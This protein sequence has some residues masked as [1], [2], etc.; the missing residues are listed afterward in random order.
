[1]PI[2]AEATRT[3]GAYLQ[4]V[5][6]IVDT[7]LDRL[8]GWRGASAH[9]SG[10]A[11]QGNGLSGLRVGN[12]LT[13]SGIEA[14]PALRLFNIWVEQK[15]VGLQSVLVSSRPIRSSR[16]A[17]PPVCSSIQR[18]GGPGSFATDLPSGGPAYPLA[19]PGVRVALQVDDRLIFHVAAFPGDPAGKG[20]GDPQRR[21][22]HGFNGFRL[23]GSRSSSLKCSGRRAATIRHGPSC[24]RMAPFRPI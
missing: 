16:S 1:M 9:L 22:L 3:G 14:E 6:L 20:E 24:R 13:V 18:S 12:I 19:T 2:F 23:K 15:L 17:P 11:I 4:R 5:G 21:D 10:Q 8:L 7:D